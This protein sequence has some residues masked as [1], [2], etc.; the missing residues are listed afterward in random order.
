MGGLRRQCPARLPA[1]TRPL[2]T[3]RRLGEAVAAAGIAL[4]AHARKIVSA[5]SD[6]Q[7]M[8]PGIDR[9]LIHGPGN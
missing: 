8:D 4:D 7:V 9:S 5:L 6:E 3:Y 2:D 1:G